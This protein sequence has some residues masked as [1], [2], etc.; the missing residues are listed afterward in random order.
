M[1]AELP[2]RP[3]PYPLMVVLDELPTTVKV[4]VAGVHVNPEF[5][6]SPPDVP[7]AVSKLPAVVLPA[8][9][10]PLVNATPFT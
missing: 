6:Y 8:I 2:P 5:P 9:V 4:V 3:I 1:F 7:V 10:D